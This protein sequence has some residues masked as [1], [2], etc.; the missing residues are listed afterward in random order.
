M[1]MNFDLASVDY[2][3]ETTRSVRK[4]LD[5]TRPVDRATVERCLEIAI[6]A[7]TGSNRQGWK[8]LIV[9]DA[10]KKTKIAEY[11][12][13]SWY[14]Y[15]G[16]ATRSAPGEEPSPQ[17]QRVVSSARYL[18]DHMHEAPMM[19]FPCV[20]GRANDASPAANAGLYGSII[21]AAWSLMLALRARGI[22]SAWTT[23]HLSYEKECN[24]VLGIPDDF[25]TAALLPVA[26][27]TGETFQKADRVPAKELT[28]WETWG[29]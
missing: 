28:Y 2:I 27:F 4:R 14:A 7:P 10:E 17:M 3:L 19:I 20:K 1:T 11:Y 22:G 26:Y 24:E 5:L 15:A 21:P 18:A 23:L 13:D 12:K 9:T 6:Q 16:V 29:A 8:W 25:T